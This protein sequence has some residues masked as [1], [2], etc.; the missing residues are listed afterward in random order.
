MFPE[1][2]WIKEKQTVFR[3]TLNKNRDRVLVMAGI[4]IH[5]DAFM[6]NV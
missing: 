5:G 6:F 4:Q 1:F 3:K 2:L